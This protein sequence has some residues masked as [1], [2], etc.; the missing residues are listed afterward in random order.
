MMPEPIEYAP[1]CQQDRYDEAKAAVLRTQ[2][3]SVRMIQREL[4]I[5]FNEATRYLQRMEID[6]V[7]SEHSNGD[8][9]RKVLVGRMG[10]APG[11]C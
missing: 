10:E 3:G 6:G 8:W 2:Q 5:G 4:Q 7:V 1:L 9:T 11:G